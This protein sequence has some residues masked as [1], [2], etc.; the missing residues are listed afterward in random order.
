[1]WVT[2]TISI[3]NF[4]VASSA[5]AF[6]VCVLYPWHKQLDDGFEKLRAEQRKALQE[7]DAHLTYQHHGERKGVLDLLGRVW[8]H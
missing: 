4:V 5:L 7:K 6:Q 1:M 2:R 3:T 8:K